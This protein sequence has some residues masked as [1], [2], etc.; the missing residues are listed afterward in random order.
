VSVINN[1][2]YSISDKEELPDQWKEHVIVQVHK[3]GDK[4][5]CNNYRE[6]SLLSTPCNILS[7]I[8]LLPLILYTYECFKTGQILCIH[9]MGVQWGSTSAVRRLK[10]ACD[11]VRSEEWYSTLIEF[12]I[13]MKLV[14]LIEMCLNETQ[15]TV[16]NLRAP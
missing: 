14:R 4:T 12:E 10:T 2:I 11:S 1:V 15:N 9:E 6:I 16:M 13:H 8:F 3:N 5:D 7:N